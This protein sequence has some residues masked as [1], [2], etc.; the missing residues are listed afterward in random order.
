MLQ[1]GTRVRVRWETDYPRSG[2]VALRIE[3]ESPAAFRVNLRVPAWS[4]RTRARLNGNPL[5][6][7]KPGQYLAIHR[8]WTKGDQVELE[9]DMAMRFEAGDRQS[10]GKVSLYRGPLLLAYDQRYNSFDEAAIPAVDVGRLNE[11]KLVPPQ[12]QEGLS[13]ILKPWVLAEL[14]TPSGQTLRLCDFASAGAAGTRYRSWLAARNCPPPPVTTRLPRDGAAIAVGPALFRWTGPNRPDEQVTE[15]QLV[16][17]PSADLAAAALKITGLQS[18]FVVLGEDALQRL[19]T[20]PENY[21]QVIAVNAFGKTENARPPARF[22]VDPTL[23]PSPVA[24]PKLGPDG[25]LV[26]AELRGAADPAFGKLAAEPRF[27]VAAGVG[28]QVGQAVQL[29]GKSQKLA[30]AIEQFPEEEYSVAFWVRIDQMPSGRI[31]QLFSAWC[32][33][34]D[35]PLRLCIDSGKL[36]ARIEAGQTYGTSGVA[37]EPGRWQ[38]VAAVKAQDKLTLFINGKP[39]PS[40][41]IPFSLYSGSHVVA[42]GGNPAFSGNEFLAATFADLRVY[43]RALSEAEI[44]AAARQK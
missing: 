19:A 41:T 15:Y 34:M 1:D 4:A 30:Y 24:L 7:L 22:I 17:S 37:V 13:A 20:H 26:R 33:S 27:Q 35:D 8:Q 42:L 16:I 29:D 10:A 14:P 32:A 18:N 9:L 6:G 40:A 36:F 38:H 31:G 21:W 28:G 39:G 23:K 43:G 11:T 12:A 2:A 44:A 3:P 25:L 5:T